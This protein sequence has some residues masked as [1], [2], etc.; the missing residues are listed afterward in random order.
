MSVTRAIAW[1]PRTIAARLSLIVFGGLLVAHGLSF[2]LLFYERYE[3]ARSMLMS[4]V[5]QDVV[6]AVNMLDRLS[7]AERTGM[8]P[9]LRRRTFGYRLGAGA[10]GPPL[11]DASARELVQRIGAALGPR[12]PLSANAV[13]GDPARF[14]MHARLRDGTVVTVDVRPSVMPIA[15]W[16]PYVLVAQ[17]ALLLLCTWAAVRLATRPLVRL[18]NAAQALHPTGEGQ[19]LQPGGPREVANAVAA[20]NAMQDRIARYMRERLQI[21]ASISHDLQ[22]PITRMGLRVEAMDAAPERDRMLEDLG[23]MQHLVREGI[24]Y[25]RSAHGGEEAVVRLDVE[26]FLESLV[27]DYRDTGKPVMLTGRAPAQVKT[28]LHAL[29]RIVANLVDNALKYAGAAE[30]HVELDAAKRVRIWIR[31]RGPGIPDDEL[32]RVLE[33]FYRLEASRNRDTGGTGLGLAIAQQ[34]ADAIGATLTL[35]NREG[36]GLD[37]VLELPADA[38][39]EMR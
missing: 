8:L 26:A 22:T 24:A 36:G 38:V 12:Y 5:E 18:A 4:N 35:R 14:E 17:L 2:G 23:Q 9:L 37:A 16:L 13:G 21:L 32:A 34:L 29:R 39:V 19:R 30:V 20:F 6:V 28:R 27:S 15:R 25:A 7:P 1:W 3:S 11:A 10:G 33:P 31:D